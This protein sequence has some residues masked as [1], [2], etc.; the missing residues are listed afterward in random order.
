MMLPSEE[1]NLSPDG[2]PDLTA[3]DDLISPCKILLHPVI[4]HL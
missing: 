1:L 3:V 2:M 4:S